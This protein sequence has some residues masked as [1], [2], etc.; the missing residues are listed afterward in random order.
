MA[1]FDFEDENRIDADDWQQGNGSFSAAF[2]QFCILELFLAGIDKG[3]NEQDQ[4][5]NYRKR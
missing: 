2:N 4:V 5:L 1:V 3:R